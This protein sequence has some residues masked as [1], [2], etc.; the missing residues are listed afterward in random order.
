VPQTSKDGGRG[1]RN[2][3]RGSVVRL[4]RMTEPLMARRDQKR[5]GKAIRMVQ[6][7]LLV[8]LRGKESHEEG[9]SAGQ[10]QRSDERCDASFARLF[11]L[12]PDFKACATHGV[13]P[14]CR[15]MHTFGV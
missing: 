12:V 7:I 13:N 1:E 15:F 9:S 5:W 3:L 11:L 10:Q 4:G 6:W 8:R 14:C 2:R